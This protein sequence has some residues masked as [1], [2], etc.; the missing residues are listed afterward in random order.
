MM[1]A[2]VSSL[3]T[4]PYKRPNRLSRKFFVSGGTLAQVLCFQDPGVGVKR[5]PYQEKCHVE[6]Q[7]L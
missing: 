2:A 7:N 3:A 4:S 1:K 6:P 5:P